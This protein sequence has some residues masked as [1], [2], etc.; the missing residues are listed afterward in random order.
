MTTIEQIK[1]GDV[2]MPPPRELSLWMRRH[3]KERGLSDA[4]LHLT[5]IEAYEGAPDK[6][7]R[8]VVITARYSQEWASG[9]VSRP[10]TFKARPETRW[11][12]ITTAEA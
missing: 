4:A 12:V 1:P 6:K 7:G 10:F 5:V 2:I 3:V 11:D 8:W 9:N